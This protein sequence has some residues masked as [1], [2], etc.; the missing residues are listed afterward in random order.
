MVIHAKIVDLK[1][2]DH[3]PMTADAEVTALLLSGRAPLLATSP[4]RT[5]LKVPVIRLEHPKNAPLKTRTRPDSKRIR[6]TRY[7]LAADSHGGGAISSILRWT[8]PLRGAIRAYPV[9]LKC[10]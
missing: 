6:P 10:R 9:P 4:L 5:D 7:W 2:W 8:F 1:F 3:A